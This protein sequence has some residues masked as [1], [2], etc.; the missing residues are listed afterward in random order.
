MCSRCVRMRYTCVLCCSEYSIGVQHGHSSAA[1][2]FCGRGLFFSAHELH[3]TDYEYDSTTY[4]CTPGTRV[5]NPVHSVPR[6][7]HHLYGTSSCPSYHRTTPCNGDRPSL[8][9]VADFLFLFVPVA[10][11]RF[12]A[13]EGQLEWERHGRCRR[14]NRSRYPSPR[15]SRRTAVSMPFTT[16]CHASRVC[17]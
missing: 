7:R 4:Y 14:T 8:D 9:V 6:H 11:L 3:G 16:Q 1:V 2:T 13:Q 17:R 12:K 15:T 10:G 5:R